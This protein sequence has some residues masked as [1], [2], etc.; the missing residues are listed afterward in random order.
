MCDNTDAYAT[1]DEGETPRC[2]NNYQHSFIE[3]CNDMQLRHVFS[4]HL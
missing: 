1:I 2:I 4:Y 3:Q